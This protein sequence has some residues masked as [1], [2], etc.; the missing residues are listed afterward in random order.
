MRTIETTIKQGDCL[1]IL[2][3]T[4]RKLTT[5]ASAGAGCANKD[6]ALILMVSQFFFADDFRFNHRNKFLKDR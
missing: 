3:N 2:H 1:D 4:L 6:S 5:P